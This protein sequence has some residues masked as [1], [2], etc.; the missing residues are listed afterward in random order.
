MNKHKERGASQL[1]FPSIPMLVLTA[2]LSRLPGGVLRIT[3]VQ[4]ADAG[5]YT[6][7][8][9]NSAGVARED[10]DLDVSGRVSRGQGEEGV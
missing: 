3:N 9:R 8:A 2:C 6:C 4:S 10:A 1:S 7:E 5:T